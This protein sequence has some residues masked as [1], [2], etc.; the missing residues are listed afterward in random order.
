[1]KLFILHGYSLNSLGEK[2]SHGVA[3]FKLLDNVNNV[4][5]TQTVCMRAKNFSF[6]LRAFVSHEY[7]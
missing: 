5:L 6:K 3:D 2:I 1:M 7:Y 4:V